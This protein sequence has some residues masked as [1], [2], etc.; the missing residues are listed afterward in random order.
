MKMSVTCEKLRAEV[1]GRCRQS[2]MYVTSISASYIEPAIEAHSVLGLQRHQVNRNVSPPTPAA[3]PS[4]D[5]APKFSSQ[6]LHPDALNWNS[7][8]PFHRSCSELPA[9]PPHQVECQTLIQETTSG[10]AMLNSYERRTFLEALMPVLSN[11]DCLYLSTL[12]QPMLKRDFL[13]DLPSELGLHILGFLE[14]PK[15]LVHASSVSKAWRTLVLDEAT[16]KQLFEKHRFGGGTKPSLLSTKPS[17]HPGVLPLSQNPDSMP[18]PT[19]PPLNTRTVTAPPSRLPGAGAA[20]SR[21]TRTSREPWSIQ[22]TGLRR[23]SA[24]ATSSTDPNNVPVS[25]HSSVSTS[26]HPTSGTQESSLSSALHETNASQSLNMSNTRTSGPL[27]AL[28]PPVTW[29]D[30]EQAPMAQPEI[31]QSAGLSRPLMSSRQ[32]SIA[33]GSNV[34]SSH[35]SSVADP[36]DPQQVGA[37]AARMEF[38]FQSSSTES[39]ERDEPNVSSTSTR[40]SSGFGT[41]SPPPL[42]RSYSSQDTSPQSASRPALGRTPRVFSQSTLS[43]SDI[44]DG[45]GSPPGRNTSSPLP[46]ISTNPFGQ[47]QIFS[48]SRSTSTGS[49]YPAGSS[50]TSADTSPRK[51]FSYQSEFKR[52]YLTESNWL[53]G[54]GRVLSS[55]AAGEEG[56]VTCLCFD[57]DWIIVGMANNQIHVFDAQTGQYVHTLSGHMLGV[58]AVALV[59]KG[60]FRAS[61]PST[62]LESVFSSDPENAPQGPLS[63]EPSFPQDVPM[64]NTSSLGDTSP[65]GRSGS[66][67]AAGPDSTSTADGFRS[68]YPPRPFYGSFRDF[69]QN[70]GSSGI[71]TDPA[72]RNS[73]PA[74]GSV[75][76]TSLGW[77]QENALAVSGSCDRDIRVWD[78]NSG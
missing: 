17:K 10:F 37:A 36:Y 69:S 50:A 9:T 78:V 61:R 41:T 47:A 74:L 35:M 8:R 77:G 63:P 72:A 73:D 21:E 48:S 55:Q 45:I 42:P 14:D 71:G 22:G 56:I 29:P 39:S 7:P 6:S 4:P 25:T 44:S 51:Q 52:A 53:R 66:S 3:S 23:T 11:D 34:S 20:S 1:K 65:F 27:S 64:F 38:P 5:N 16:W 40:R 2:L 13:K 15:D 68:E 60:G 18:H 28:L 19:A 67:A 75:C 30:S 26:E 54:P 32:D 24:T 57:S 43:F 76:G 33:S 59:S 46:A 70:T 58:W 12:L 49:G 31:V 62:E